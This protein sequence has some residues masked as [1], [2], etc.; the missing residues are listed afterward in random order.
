MNF[1]ELVLFNR[2]GPYAW[3]QLNQIGTAIQATSNSRAR[4]TRPYIILLL[5]CGLAC[6]S[7]LTSSYIHLEPS[8]RH[9]RNVY[10]F[11]IL[12]SLLIQHMVS[13]SGIGHPWDHMPVYAVIVQSSTTS[14]GSTMGTLYE[15]IQNQKYLNVMHL[16]AWHMSSRFHKSWVLDLAWYIDIF[17]HRK[18]TETQGHLRKESFI[19]FLKWWTW[20]YRLRR[21]MKHYLKGIA[22]GKT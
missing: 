4:S 15:M 20:K 8:S 5:L 2:P 16:T 3:T 1:L 9:W 13:V 19:K 22:T 10:L 6:E 18:Y 21:E 12:Y 11:L 14:D 7:P 17:H